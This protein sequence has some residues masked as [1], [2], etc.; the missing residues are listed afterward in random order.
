MRVL[1]ASAA[2]MAIALAGIAASAQDADRSV[3]GGGIK[4]AA[5]RGR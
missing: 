4:A 2:V 3:A 5:G 1:Q